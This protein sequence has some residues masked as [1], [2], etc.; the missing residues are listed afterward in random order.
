LFFFFN[1]PNKYLYTDLIKYGTNIISNLL[2]L[3]NSSALF[4]LAFFYFKLNIAMIDSNLNFPFFFFNDY[5]VNYY[6]IGL[7]DSF[8]IVDLKGIGELLYDTFVS[9]IISICI[10]LLLGTIFIIT[11]H[12]LGLTKQ[13]SEQHKMFIISNRRKVVFKISNSFLNRQDL[14]AQLKNNF[15]LRIIKKN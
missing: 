3:L 5:I 4:I 8:I 1:L 10:L 14:T 9:E 2:L 12:F 15:G 13:I 7:V 11:L 6:T